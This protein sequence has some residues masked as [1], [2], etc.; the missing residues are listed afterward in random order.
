MGS[1]FCVLFLAGFVVLFF[2]VFVCGLDFG[3]W[4]Y[5]Q[6]NPL[7]PFSPFP[8]LC[9]LHFAFSLPSL[10]HFPFSFSFFF[11]FVQNLHSVYYLFGCSHLI[12]LIC[13]A[14]ASTLH[15]QHKYLRYQDLPSMHQ[16]YGHP[17]QQQTSASR[18]QD[19]R[20]L[21]VC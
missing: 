17:T 19:A 7:Y 10:P 8:V 16:A 21:G 12:D 14:F 5:V 1:E 4:I 20:V 9:I 18:T 13:T 3:V 15:T 2:E 6:K 11:P